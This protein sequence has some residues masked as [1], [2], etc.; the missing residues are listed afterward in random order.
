[1]KNL[2]LPGRRGEGEKSTVSSFA[3]VFYRWVR[4]TCSHLRPSY[5]GSVADAGGVGEGG[6]DVNEDARGDTYEH[7][8]KDVD[9]GDVGA[10]GRAHLAHVEQDSC[11]GCRS[12]SRCMVLQ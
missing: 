4:A 11:F 2:V 3:F 9:R 8:D 10:N 6:S 1:M 5:G 12:S 7:L